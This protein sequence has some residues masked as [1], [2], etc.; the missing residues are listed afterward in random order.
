MVKD[1]K[2]GAILPPIVL[3]MVIEEDIPENNI[4]E[5][6]FIDLLKNIS[7][8]RI[9]IIDG[10]QRTTAFHEASIT[11]GFIRVEFWLTD[12]IQNLTYRMLVLNTGQTPW[13]LRRQIEVVYRPLFVEITNELSKL[14]DIKGKFVISTNDN[15]QVRVKAGVYHSK[16]FIELYMA[17]GLRKEKVDIKTNLA[18][19]FSKLDMIEALTNANFFKNFINM[20]SWLCRLDLAFGKFSSLSQ[21]GRF[22]NGQDIFK[23]QPAKIGFMTAAARKIYGIPGTEHSEER[24]NKE[25]S[26]IINKCKILCESASNVSDED[27]VNFFCFD[28]LNEK[29]KSPSNKNIGEYERSLFVNA[30]KTLFSDEYNIEELNEISLK[31]LWHA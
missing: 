23:S 18:D 17:F 13:D 31:P 1:L 21:E 7:T 19:E 10:M 16:D 30:F 11:E 26:I 6:K 14:D 2:Q 24:K 25:L 15:K 27:A 5:N 29:I 4:N 20:F 3:G 22:I 12:K 28:D 9:S 8:E